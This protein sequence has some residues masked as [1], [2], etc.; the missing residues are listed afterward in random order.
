MQ[1]V[2]PAGNLPSLGSKLGI[3]ATN[4]WPGEEVARGDHARLEPAN[5]AGC[6]SGEACGRA[7]VAGAARSLRWTFSAP[8]QVRRLVA[9]PGR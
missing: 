8:L 5:R 3:D 6:G 7:A 9:S 1:L 2:Y 4:K